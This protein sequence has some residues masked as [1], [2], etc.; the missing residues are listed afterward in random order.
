MDAAAKSAAGLFSFAENAGTADQSYHNPWC[1]L[2]LQI[3][4]RRAGRLVVELFADVVPRTAENFRCL[5]TGERGLARDSGKALHFRNTVFHR[6]IKGFMAQGGDTTNRNGTGGVS[7][8]GGKFDDEQIWY[9]HTHGG[10][11]SMANAGPNTN[12]SQ[13]F[14]CFE[15]TPHLNEKHTIFGRVIDGWDVVKKIEEN[16]TENDLPVKPVT[17]VDCGEL[18]QEEKLAENKANIN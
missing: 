9:P 18:A 2:D 6:V 13:F 1:F 11:L 16:P 4:G 7:I 17:I 15:A 10:V 8:Y 14:I 3:G 5:C 12:G